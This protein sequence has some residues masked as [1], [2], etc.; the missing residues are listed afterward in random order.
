MTPISF[1]DTNVQHL[2]LILENVS[3]GVWLLDNTLQTLTV[4]SAG[5]RLLGRRPHQIIGRPYAEVMLDTPLDGSGYHHLKELFEQALREMASIS[6][7]RGIPLQ[8]PS[9]R[10]CTI[11]GV[12]IPL[13]NDGQ[14]IGVASIFR[15]VS[16]H[17]DVEQLQAELLSMASH[18][19]RTPLTAV[20]S[21]LDYMLAT[22][23]LSD[24]GREVLERAH[25]QSKQLSI[26]LRELLEISH[27]TLGQEIRLRLEPTDLRQLLSHS[28]KAF[29]ATMP[30]IRVALKTP[31][32]L[33]T[34]STDVTKLKI[35]INHLLEHAARRCHPTGSIEIK[36]DEGDFQAIIRLKDNGPPLEEH[37]FEKIFWPFYPLEDNI[38][39]IPFGYTIGLYSVRKLARLMGGEMWV[40]RQEDR[41]V[42]LNFALPY[43]RK[44]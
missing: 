3:D 30:E 13:V 37:Q 2:A 4:N 8:L 38:N 35:I 29:G 14:S 23:A 43:W 25:Q 19:L 39:S 27:L 22:Q 9:G 12:A 41:G 26:V 11:E 31:V 18:N 36:V 32:R 1:M 28:V 21:S 24:K 17:Q 42:C 7:G 5:A 15:E 20:Q 10:V 34:V 33:P 6:F 40:D 44:P 16:V